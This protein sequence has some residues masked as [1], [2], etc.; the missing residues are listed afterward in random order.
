MEVA[1]VEDDE[2]S[3]EKPC[4]PVKQVQDL[5]NAIEEIFLITLNKFSVIGGAQEH[6]I[7]LSSL[8]EIIGPHKQSWL[9]LPTLD[10]VPDQT[11][12]CVTIIH[13]GIELI[14]IR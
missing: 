13:M 6:L 8:A 14:Q 2:S 7:H 9:D 11:L 12:N 4:P 5:N 1:E 10:Q 3:A